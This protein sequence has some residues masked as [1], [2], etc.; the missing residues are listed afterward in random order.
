MPS[1]SWPASGRHPPGRPQASLVTTVRLPAL[2]YVHPPPLSPRAALDALASFDRHA[3]SSRFA[4]LAFVVAVHAALLVAVWHLT[5][6]Q[7]IL[8]RATPI[9]V[10]LL[11]PQP[12]PPPVRK[13]TPPPPPKAA[14]KIKMVET[15]PVQTVVPLI[16]PLVPP[17]TP[18]S[19]ITTVTEAP[20]APPVELAAPAVTSAPPAPLTPPRFDADYLRNPA[21]AYPPLARRNGEQGRVL[22]RVLVGPDGDAREVTIQTSSGFERLDR[23][24]QETV[25]QWRFVP[26]RLGANAVA[27]WVIVPISFSLAHGARD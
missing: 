27:A 26:A 12:S 9:I 6:A 18:S 14:P 10:R 21:P 13:P 3:R 8:T 23:A 22:L 25:R 2:A 1:Q 16:E 4:G 17:V 20:P 19:P 11:S 7:Q 24:A 15:P 5:P